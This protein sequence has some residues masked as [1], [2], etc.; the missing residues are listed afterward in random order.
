M[1]KD[2]WNSNTRTNILNGDPKTKLDEKDLCYTIGG[3]TLRFA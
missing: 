2:K 3:L 1:R